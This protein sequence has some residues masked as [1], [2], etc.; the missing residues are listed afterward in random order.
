M[1]FIEVSLKYRLQSP[2]FVCFLTHTHTHTHTHTKAE[3][4][5]HT[6]THGH[7]K[8]SW[9]TDNVDLWICWFLKVDQNYARKCH[10]VT[11]YRVSIP[12]KPNNK[13]MSLYLQSLQKF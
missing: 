4:H 3:A 8:L 9:K 2:S 11:A 6:H 13:Y 7:T 5:T 12:Q 10:W 1:G